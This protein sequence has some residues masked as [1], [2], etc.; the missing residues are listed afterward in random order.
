MMRLRAALA[1]SALIVV[2]LTTAAIPADAAPSVALSR[3]CADV[4]VILARGSGQT[5]GSSKEMNTFLADLKADLDGAATVNAYELGTEPQDGEQYPAVNVSKVTNG[6]A[7]GAKFSGG[8]AFDYGNSVNTGIRELISYGMPRGFACPSSRFVMAGYSQG[9][10]VIGQGLQY[11]GSLEQQTDFVALFGDPKL[12]LPE[13]EGIWPAACRGKSYSPWRRV[14]GDCRTDGGSLGAR[15][16]YLPVGF[17]GKTGLWCNNND[18]VCGSSKYAWVTSGHFKYP[19][20]GNGDELAAAEAARRIGASLGGGAVDHIV[21]N[22]GHGHSTNLDVVFLLDTTGSMGGQI[23]ASQVFASRMADAVRAAHGRV[24]LVT[25]KDAG[26]EYT[27]RI[28]APLTDDLA[29][30]KNALNRQYASGGGD[31]PEA[32]LHG[33]MTA[34]DGLD[35][36]DGATKAAIV[37]TDADWHDPDLVDGTT[38]ESM[39]A[40]SLQIDPVNVYPVVPAYVAAR[41]EAV[42]QATSGK[43]IVDEGDT[44]TSLMTALG[45]ITSRPFAALRN[46]AYEANVGEEITFDA[47]DSYGLSAPIATYDWDFDGDNVFDAHTTT[48]TINRTYIA[49]FDGTMQVRVTDTS[50]GLGS[51]SVPVRIG[52][53]APE[54]LAAPSVSVRPTSTSGEVTLSWSASGATQWLITVGDAVLG[55][56]TDNPVTITD[57]ERDQ[58]VT[59]SVTPIAADGTL[60]HTGSATLTAGGRSAATVYSARDLTLTNALSIAGTNGSVATGGNFSCNSS[61]SI[62]GDVTVAGTAYLTNG[63]SIGGQLWAGS[64][65]RMDSSAK[66]AGAVRSGGDV[67]LQSTN[68]IGGDVIAAGKVTSADGRTDAQLKA[69]GVV[70]GTISRRAAVQAPDI[71]AAAGPVPA[72]PLTGAAATAPAS[73][74]SWLNQVAVAHNAPAWA[75]GRSA[76]PGCT[77]ADG[78][79][80]VNGAQVDVATATVIDARP[81]SS[82]CAAVSL[83]GMRLRLSA[84]LTL[85]TGGLSSVGSFSVVSADGGHHQLRIVSQTAGSGIELA[86]GASIDPLIG[87]SLEATGTVTV[88]AGADLRAVV[89]AGV[90]RSDGTVVLRAS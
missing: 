3:P 86:R 87:V 9:A 35:W 22:I 19:E 14:I 37:L 41:Y 5:V 50:G 20:P 30:F 80:S 42:A 58:D 31:T 34:F 72:D 55:Y 17:L 52:Q 13:G 39:A 26:D 54:L 45:Q 57:I 88:H 61:V 64:G 71:A 16:P 12:Y 65:V 44:V 60:G 24:A 82:G 70:G 79:Y 76:K 85:V 59:F 43:V 81:A 27:A 90:F 28:D 77:M 73:W 23:N 1:A 46:S 63:C 15:K 53:P 38:L 66:V 32:M 75:S 25:Y 4:E 48:A 36:K 33:L 49:P 7:I 68:R 78:A 62:A 29:A 74:A 18:F 56:T 47:S 89:R 10:Q 8:Q 11:L 67:T 6:N 21:W 84:D 40:R 2:S 51:A 69:G 83:Q